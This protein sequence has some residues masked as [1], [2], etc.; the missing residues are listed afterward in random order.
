MVATLGKT[1][2]TANVYFVEYFSLQGMVRELWVK[3]C[4]PNAM[5]H[6]A[7]G[8]TLSTKAAHCE[9]RKPFFLFDTMLCRMHI[10]KLQRVSARLVFNYYNEKDMQLCAFGWQTIVFKDQHRKTCRMPD[11]FRVAAQAILVS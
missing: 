8:L 2:A 5:R 11:D 6:F 9:F 7:S 4:V 3:Q 10:E 1:N